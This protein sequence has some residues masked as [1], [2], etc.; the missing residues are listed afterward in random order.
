MGTASHFMTTPGLYEVWENVGRWAA[1]K[2]DGYFGAKGMAYRVSGLVM[3]PKGEW[4]VALMTDSLTGEEAVP[5]ER[6]L[7]EFKVLE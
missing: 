5:L 4:F 7:L 6:Y 3:S 1:L 2:Q